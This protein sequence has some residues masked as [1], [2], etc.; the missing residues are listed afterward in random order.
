[1]PGGKAAPASEW[2]SASGLA[3]ELAWE[4]VSASD[5][6]PV[7]ASVS[8]QALALELAQGLELGLG[9]GSVWVWESAS[10]SGSD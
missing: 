5:R 2:E 7:L 8:D 6:G 9:L 4:R 10:A 3:Q 1:M